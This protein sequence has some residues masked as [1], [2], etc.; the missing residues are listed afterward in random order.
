MELSKPWQ[1]A[2]DILALVVTGIFLFPIFWWALTSIK[3]NSAVFDKDRNHLGTMVTWDVVTERV[4]MET[5]STDYA[6][7]VAAINKSQAVIEFKLD[8][9]IVTANDHFLA[10]MG[11]TLGE[12]QGRHHSMFAEPSFAAWFMET[13]KAHT[14]LRVEQAAVAAFA[15]V[16]DRD[17][18]GARG[19]AIAALEAT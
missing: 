12:I 1:I 18:A 14:H 13:V 8:G 6:G 19:A 7:Q 11:Y 4:A 16:P 9:T 3:P 5:Q 2:R 15:V 17:M 10:A